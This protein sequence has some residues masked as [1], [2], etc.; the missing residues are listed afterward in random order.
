MHEHN[1]KIKQKYSLPRALPLCS[2]YH[3]N[4]GWQS[5]PNPSGICIFSFVGANVAALARDNPLRLAVIARATRDLLQGS[6]YT[7][8]VRASVIVA[9]CASCQFV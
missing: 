4:S 5:A 9:E 6:W 2:C 8:L 1:H 7:K 3:L